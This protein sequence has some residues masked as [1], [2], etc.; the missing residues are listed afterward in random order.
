LLGGAIETGPL[1]YAFLRSKTKRFQDSRLQSRLQ[2][3]GLYPRVSF[4]HFT[5]LS[6]ARSNRKIFRPA[7]LV[8]FARTKPARSSEVPTGLP[9]CCGRVPLIVSVLPWRANPS[10]GTRLALL[11]FALTLPSCLN[12]LLNSTIP[13]CPPLRN[14]L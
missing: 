4:I 3:R 6:P 2:P 12:C 14:R 11:C 9:Y 1:L 13:P 10:H 8:W 7:V 5:Q